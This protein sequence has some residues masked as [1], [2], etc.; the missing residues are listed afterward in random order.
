MFDRKLFRRF[1]YTVLA[2]VIILIGIGLLMITSATG[3]VVNE[4]QKYVFLKKQII[5]F[6]IGIGL[7]TLAIS[8]DYNLIGKF[9]WYLYGTSIFILLLVKLIGVEINGAKSWIQFGSFSFQP[10]EFA[11]ILIIIFLA[12]YISILYDTDHRAINS[13]FQLGIIIL[14]LAV[15]LMLIFIQPD[16]GTAMVLTVV[17]ATM[18]FTA[19]LTLKYFFAAGATILGAIPFLWMSLK[20][21]QKDRIEVFLNPELDPLNRGFQII[22]SKIAIGSGGFWG[23][24]LFDGIQTQMGFLPFKET[25]FIFSVIG[26]ELG[27]FWGMIILLLFGILLLK[28]VD[29][30]RNSKDLF[31]TLIVSGVT[32]MIG[33]HVFQNIGMTIGIMPIT[34]IPLPFISYGGTS[35]MANMIG[36]GLVLNVGMRRNKITF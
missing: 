19:D 27:F 21:Y 7:M 25:D 34:G 32:A 23:K 18:L 16:F 9:F 5:A 12:K 3:S 8:I 2:I 14:F 29:V 26:E 22:Q 24:G 10:S 35:L 15:P 31:G 20:D 30:M 13:P 11:K 6:V 17:I 4:A 28:F 33:I 1:D 36:V